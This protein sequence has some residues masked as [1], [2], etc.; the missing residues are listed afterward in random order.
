VTDACADFRNQICIHSAVEAGGDFSVAACRVNRWQDC[1]SQIRRRDCENI[2]A[3]DCIWVD[4]VEGMNFTTGGKP[5]GF[6]NPTAGPAF[7]GGAPAGGG[8]A[9]D[10]IVG[11]AGAA[12]PLGQMFQG[13]SGEATGSTSPTGAAITNLVASGRGQWEPDYD[14]L[15]K[16]SKFNKSEEDFGGMCVPLVPPGSKFWDGEGLCSM[17][18]ANCEVIIRITEKYESAILGA[19]GDKEYDHEMLNSTGQVIVKSECL[20]WTEPP[21]SDKKSY[22]LTPT[23]EWAKRVNAICTSLGDCGADININD[24]YT[25]DGYIW[26]YNEDTFSLMRDTGHRGLQFTGKVV[27]NTDK[28]I[29]NEDLKLNREDYVLVKNG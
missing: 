6:T 17:A 25:D 16:V 26:K 18:S 14:I 27:S 21:K 15:N 29:I 3:R 2:D 9:V 22:S 8:S 24:K 20:E 5:S 23:P 4:K 12:A 19:F 13:G 11:V 7:G 28:I 10:G 1:T